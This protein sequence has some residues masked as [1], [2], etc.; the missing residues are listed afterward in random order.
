[1]L[2]PKIFIPRLKTLQRCSSSM[3]YNTLWKDLIMSIK[4]CVILPALWNCIFIPLLIEFDETYFGTSIIVPCD[5]G[6][7]PQ[8]HNK[9]FLEEG[10]LP[11]NWH[12]NSCL[13]FRLSDCPANFQTFSPPWS[14]EPVQQIH[15]SLFPVVLRLLTSDIFTLVNIIAR[16]KKNT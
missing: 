1:M 10:I 13:N 2:A 14:Q 7:C 9:R 6:E 8:S 12:V 3:L 11:Q 4:Y 16:T 5:G 15:F